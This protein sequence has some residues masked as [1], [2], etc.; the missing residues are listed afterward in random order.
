MAVSLIICQKR[1][2]LLL[3]NTFLM[4]ISLLRLTAWAVER[5]MKLIQA[6]S[7]MKT[8]I[9]ANV[10]RVGK[11]MVCVPKLPKRSSKCMVAR[12]CKKWRVRLISHSSWNSWPQSARQASEIFRNKKG[13]INAELFTVQWFRGKSDPY[14]APCLPS[15]KI[16]KMFWFVF[17][18]ILE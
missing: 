13:H 15:P 1:F 16:K 4:P 3:P 11:L 9:R 10:Q 12:G 2:H 5:L 17:D 8:P 18:S 6:I 7:M 14:K